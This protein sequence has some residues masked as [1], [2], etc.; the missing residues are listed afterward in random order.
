MKL[1]QAG[2]MQTLVRV[3]AAGNI[4]VGEPTL[5]HLETY[6]NKLIYHKGDIVCQEQIRDTSGNAELRL[7]QFLHSVNQTAR[8]QGLLPDPITGNVGALTATEMFDTI[9]R[10]R[11]YNG[12][13]VV[14][15]AVA[16]TN[17]YTSGPL[18]I[19]IHVE[20]ISN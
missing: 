4:M 15:K 3:I 18:R 7:M 9:S 20:P 16:D 5:V 6:D 19:N 13:E 10:I 14:I 1:Q 12:A 11:A 2:D 8:D 17:I